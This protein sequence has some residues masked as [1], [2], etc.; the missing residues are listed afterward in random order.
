MISVYGIPPLSDAERKERQDKLYA[1]L[2]A[3]VEA[4][5]INPECDYDSERQTAL[6]RK[7]ALSDLSLSQRDALVEL[8]ENNEKE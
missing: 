1:Y 7:I 8:L 3:V 2:K 6:L 5:L 4:E